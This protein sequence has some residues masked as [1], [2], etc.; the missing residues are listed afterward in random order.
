MFLVLCVHLDVL[1]AH[2]ER[3]V[4]SGAMAASCFS[5][6]DLALTLWTLTSP[7]IAD[8][9]TSQSSL[10]HQAPCPRE[11]LLEMQTACFRP[12]KKIK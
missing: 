1:V 11:S 12:Q 8:L 4:I 9:G 10:S 3:T 7:P 5:G 2:K 6:L